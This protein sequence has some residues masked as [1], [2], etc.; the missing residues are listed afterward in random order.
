MQ[1]LGAPT[2]LTV[3]ADYTGGTLAAGTYYYQVNCRGVYGNGVP[4]AEVSVTLTQT[5]Q[6]K[7]SWNPVGGATGYTVW[8]RGAGTGGKTGYVF[9]NGPGTGQPTAQNVYT[10]TGTALTITAMPTSDST[11]NNTNTTATRTKLAR[12]NSAIHRLADRYGLPVIDQ[13][14]LLVDWANGSQYKANYT[15]DGTHPV[16]KVQRAMGVNVSNALAPYLP[17]RMPYLVGDQLDPTVLGAPT[18]GVLPAGVNS[19]LLLPNTASGYTR[20]GGW[21]WYGSTSDGSTSTLTTDPN[22][23]GYVYTVNRAG[24]NGLYTDFSVF[25]GFSAGDRI[26]FAVKVKSSGLDAIEGGGVSVA[27]KCTGS[28]GAQYI[29]ALQV[30]RDVPTT[31]L[32]GGWAIW[33]GEAVVPPGTTQLLLQFYVTGQGVSASI[34]QPT[35]RNLTALSIA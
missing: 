22:V 34:A 29:T 3:T 10:D 28:T 9:I 27:L 7:L 21:S 25:S 17:P 18:G 13:Y 1:A 31:S 19:G 2:G 30:T 26:S 23:L 20:P 14:G 12:V 5:G 6:V 11:A 35:I 15:A 32:P 4:S 16:P 8:G 33:Y 24:W